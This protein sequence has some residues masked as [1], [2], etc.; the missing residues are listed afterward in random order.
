MN[1]EVPFVGC[2][3]IMGLINARKMERIGRE[4]I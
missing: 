2:L 1:I 4:L 3:D